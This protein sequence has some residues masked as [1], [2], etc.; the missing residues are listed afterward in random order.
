MPVTLLTVYFSFSN[1]YFL[2]EEKL[3]SCFLTSPA[4]GEERGGVNDICKCIFFRL[5]FRALTTI[6]L[7]QC[8]YDYVIKLVSGQ[9]GVW[10][11]GRGLGGPGAGGRRL[12]GGCGASSFVVTK[13]PLTLGLAEP[14][15]SAS[16]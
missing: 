15:V 5:G 3:V 10:C 9:T 11:A 6:L 16:D 12:V 14:P 4:V 2:T 8:H 7:L 1:I 13:K